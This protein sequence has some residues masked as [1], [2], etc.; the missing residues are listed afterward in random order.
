MTAS[1]S[2]Q[3][4]SGGT[5]TGTPVS[6]GT[7][8]APGTFRVTGTREGL[9][10]GTTSNGHVIVPDDKFIALPACTSSSCPWLTPGTIHPLWG[11]RV[12][13]GADCSVRV[14]NP[15]TGVCVVA[16]VW[17]VGP[18]YTN[19]D[20]WNPT[21]TRRLNNLDTTVNILSQGYPG[22][23]AAR[24]GMDTGYGIAP[25]GIGISNKGYE[26][27]NRSAIDIAD[28][29]WTDLGFDFNA[30]I[31]HNGVIVTFLWMS[32]ENASTAAA[33]CDNSANLI[34]TPSATATVVPTAT[35][36]KT[37][38]ATA[39]TA[40]TAATPTGTASLTLSA[41]S[42]GVGSPTTLTGT[43]FAPGET[44][45]FFWDSTAT[46]LLGTAT[47]TTSGGV[48]R[49]LTV[50][51]SVRGAHP[52][53]ARGATSGRQ[54][55]ATFTVTPRLLRTP[56]QA[57]PG[58]TMTITVKGFGP[59]EGVK[60]TWLTTTGSV[61]G[62]ATTN[63]V[64]T[65]TVTI[66]LPQA[67]TGWRDYTGMGLTSGVRAWGAIQVLPRLTLSPTSAVSGATVATTLQGFPASSGVTVYWNRTATSSGTAVCSGTT[68]STGS[69]GCSFRA[70][71]AAAG[72]YPVV[73]VAG[74]TSAQAILSLGTT[75]TSSAQIS[76]QSLDEPTATATATLPPAPTA[77]AT[78]TTTT[79][80]VM[81]TPTSAPTATPE[82]T[83]TVAPTATSAPV[84]QELM[85]LAVADASVA[86]SSLGGT[87]EAGPVKD[88]TVLTA[89]G[90]EGALV[91]LT[92]QVTGVEAGT[93]VDAS[94]ILTGAGEV[95][96]V[97]GALGAL[98][99]VWIDETGMTYETVPAYEAP[100]ALAADGS[101]AYI[102][103]IEPGTERVIDV[104]GT[105]RADGTITFV[106]TGTS[107]APV[108]VASRESATP[109]RLMLTVQGS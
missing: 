63:T 62:T 20:W 17:D 94:L 4:T 84:N 93:V 24:N 109:P 50:P 34:A 3:I 86:P 98:P 52:V 78:A 71:M 89:G 96:G 69:F 44:V 10:G 104:T 51:D 70:P 15:N 25:S 39:T 79:P 57:A 41:T 21:E 9:V 100:P 27:G 23:D 77:T 72:V 11:K 35:P 95:G 67:P 54:G 46:P 36:T 108:T 101:A 22:V 13:C 42:G 87:P 38:T 80:A 28:G 73:G 91:F 105:V 1:T 7:V 5:G 18:W 81:P 92:F 14:T 64:G 68:S 83:A 12:E 26:V 56:T 29:V 90:P 107:D 99:D 16:P 102:E 33:A 37:P 31:V 97:G 60:L 48:S 76:S 74:T 55:Q 103:W 66:T 49:T 61:L 47:A 65:G 88:S 2:Y 75:S 32:G 8:L 30:G 106:L 53:I 19:D 58:A 43:G 82:P 45:R 59:S 85:L 6:G 40:T